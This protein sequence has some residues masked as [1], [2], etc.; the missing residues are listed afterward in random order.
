M[1]YK[2]KKGKSGEGIVLTC[3][4]EEK[5]TVVYKSQDLSGPSFSDCASCDYQI[6]TG[7]AVSDPV[8]E[9]HIKTFFPERLKCGFLIK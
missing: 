8:N 9:S 2:Y 1:D 6:G 7:Y 5:H 4:L 3:P